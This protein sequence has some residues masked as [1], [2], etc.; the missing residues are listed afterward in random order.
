[1]YINGISENS[2]NDLHIIWA[3]IILI[4]VMIIKF[5]DLA[6]ILMCVNLSVGNLDKDTQHLWLENLQN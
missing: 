2:E 6:F 1:M 5:A 3:Y 4:L